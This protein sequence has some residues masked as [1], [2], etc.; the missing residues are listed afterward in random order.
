[1]ACV[2]TNEKSF[3][4]LISKYGA[5]SGTVENAIKIYMD[6][7]NLENYDPNS[8]DFINHMDSYFQLKSNNF[9]PSKGEYNRVHALWEKIN[10]KQDIAD[11]KTATK[12]YN[13]LV[14]I[15]GEDNVTIFETSSGRFRVRVAE[16]MFGDGI[17]SDKELLKEMYDILSKAPRDKNGNLLAPNGKKSNLTERQYA[18]VRTKAFKEWFGDWEKYAP[19]SD[20]S[21]VEEQLVLVFERIPELSK[22]GSI[23][24][25]AAY[26]ADKFPNSV[27]RN[28]YW[29]GTNEDFSEGF[30]SAKKGKGSGAPETQSRN[31]FYLAKQAWTVL[32][33]VNG[34]NRNSVDK[35]GFAHWNKLW[36]EL[37]EIMSN[38]RRENNNW[39]DMVIG[40][41]TVRQGIPNK[42][43]VFNRDKGGSNGKWLSERKADYGYENKSDKEFFEDI[44]GVQ[45]GKDT[46]NTWTKRNA[47]VFK[48]LEKTQK[49]IYPAII[50][51]QNPIREKG[52]NTYY[53]EQR[54]LFTQAERESNDAILGEQTDNEFG[55]DV[56]VVLNASEKNVHFL[57]TKEDV[58]GFKK[59]LEENRA[60]KVVDE[61]GEP[62][63]VYHGSKN[64]NF[65]IF[66]Y[67]YLKKADSGFFFSSDKEYAKQFGDIR[68]FFLNIKNPNITNIPLNIDNVEKLLTVDYKEG[69]D[70]IQGHDDT[71]TNEN[72]YHSKKQEYVALRPNQIKSATNNTGAFSKSNDRIDDFKINVEATVEYTPIG[73]SRQ[74]Y[75]IRGN[76]IFNKEGKEVFKTDSV[77]RNRIFANLAVQQGRA[78]WGEYVPAAG[79]DGRG[80]NGV[81]AHDA[82]R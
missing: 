23:R 76:K 77:D 74:T 56:A 5:S 9:Y 41:E 24:E 66:D 44:L 3:K 40:E 7:N 63:V 17:T 29:H 73:K 32:Q 78:V 35:N 39:K 53:E 8:P 38:G 11:I 51:T 70:G 71:N 81:P 82:R 60:S 10:P 4:E 69:T 19:K 80:E 68:E 62:L 43:G 13:T 45:W 75:T 72:L 67:N 28:V 64:K 61:N 26:L 46:F 37:K 27:D 54:G 65:S 14:G 31:D 1:M 47:E 30:K 58:E 59:W 57:G 50:N 22:I 18:Q 15:F 12:E 34:V 16:P 55:S 21:K 25:Y 36:W 2:N 52:Q 49:G 42:K 48:A 20:F 6:K 79:D 33:Y